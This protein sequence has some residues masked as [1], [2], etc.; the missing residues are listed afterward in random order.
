[1][2]IMRILVIALSNLVY[3]TVYQDIIAHYYVAGSPD[4]AEYLN[5]D[6]INGLNLYSYC[7]NNPVCYY[8]LSGNSPS[9]L[10]III[11]I[12]VA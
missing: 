12:I 4:S 10:P 1:M 2:V 3:T 11:G 5:P 7:L 6:V 9:I 8:D